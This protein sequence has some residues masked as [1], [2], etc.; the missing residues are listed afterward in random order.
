MP[1]KILKVSI[2]QGPLIIR[3]LKGKTLS[4]EISLWSEIRGRESFQLLKKGGYYTL[5]LLK[6]IDDYR[7]VLGAEIELIDSLKLISKVWEFSGGSFLK[8]E[9]QET[10]NIPIYESNATTV[11]EELMQLA[12]RS[13]VRASLTMSYDIIGGYKEPPL[14]KASEL[15][16]KAKK[17]DN[18]SKLFHYFYRSRTDDQTWYIHLY[19]VREILSQIYGSEKNAK[20]GLDISSTKWTEFGKSLNRNDLRH[21]I[22][23]MQNVMQPKR[24]KLETYAKEWI[25]A[26]LK[27]AGL[28]D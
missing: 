26:H 23:N 16:K 6:K 13:H 24:Q 7:L 10:V 3:S 21:A 22:P 17:D 12:G 28:Q 25:L 18:L 15:V 4:N 9:R 2:K 8:I 19:K 1:N 27:S 11:E 14:R 5:S 20:R